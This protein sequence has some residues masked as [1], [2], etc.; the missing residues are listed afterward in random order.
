MRTD[1]A[2]RVSGKFW[3]PACHASEL[4]PP[5]FLPYIDYSLVYWSD[6]H[7]AQWTP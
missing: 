6:L 5:F 3:G 4:R 2:E 1:G 7:P